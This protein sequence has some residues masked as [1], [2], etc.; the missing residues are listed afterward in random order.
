MYTTSTVQAKQGACGKLSKPSP[1]TYPATCD[2]DTFLP[3][4]LNTFYTQNIEP[5]QKSTPQSD[6]QLSLSA[7]SMRKTLARSTHEKRLGQTTYTGRVLKAYAHQLLE[8]LVDIFNTFLSQ[9]TVPL[10]FK[11]TPPVL[12]QRGPQSQ[13]STTTDQ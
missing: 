11:S 8:V 7:A 1:T 13:S 6:E 4:S 9:A 12:F 3:D 5:V 10:Y 2:N